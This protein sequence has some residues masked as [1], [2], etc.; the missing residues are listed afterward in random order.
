ME[1]KDGE[2]RG[3][4]TAT[5]LLKSNSVI[6]LSSLIDL[7]LI[8]VLKE[9]WIIYIPLSDRCFSREAVVDK[10]LNYVFIAFNRF[11]L[12]YVRYNHGIN[13]WSIVSLMIIITKILC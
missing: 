5:V 4:N 12:N 10:Y 7:L 13:Y 1:I 6:V 9:I 2:K 8:F 11:L 3:F